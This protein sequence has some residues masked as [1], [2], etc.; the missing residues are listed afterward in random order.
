M[1]SRS[2]ELLN[3]IRLISDEIL[4]KSFGNI[5][6]E[7]YI[8]I[9]HYGNIILRFNINDSNYTLDDLDNYESMMNECVKDEFLVDF[10]GSVYKNVGL[11]HQELDTILTK[12]QVKYNDI[13]IPKSIHDNNI[14]EDARYLLSLCNLPIEQDVW[15]IQLE[16]EINL[17]ILGNKTGML[18]T[19]DSNEGTIN[20]YELN[21]IQAEGLMKATIYAKLNNISL[22]K[23]LLND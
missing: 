5:I 14:K 18:G 1:Y 20:V 15:E 13:V 19:Y 23:V 21:R 12:C 7:E 4:L 9:P 8:I 10:M 22:V 6:F 17:F 16:E 3:R 2:E 11:N